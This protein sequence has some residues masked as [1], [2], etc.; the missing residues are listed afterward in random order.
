MD[1]L[2]LGAI[3]GM[4]TFIDSIT[5]ISSMLTIAHADV[6]FDDYACRRRAHVRRHRILPDREAGLD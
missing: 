2:G 1:Y 6:D 5:T 4:C 3:T